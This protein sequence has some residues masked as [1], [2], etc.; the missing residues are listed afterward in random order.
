MGNPPAL[1]TPP[2][3]PVLSAEKKAA[4]PNLKELPKLFSE[5]PIERIPEPAL[6]SKM[7]ESRLSLPSAPRLT[8]ISMSELEKP[9]AI[10]DFGIPEPSMELP[11]IDVPDITFPKQGKQEVSDAI[12]K[13]AAKEIV[14]EK[15]A[16][17]KRI[18]EGIPPIEE[19]EQQ[20]KEENYQE[21]S[22]PE[23]RLVTEIKGTIFIPSNQFN[24]VKNALGSIKDNIKNSD[25]ALNKIMGLK[26]L[27][28]SA[29]EGWHAGVESIQR[30]LI[31]IDRMLFEKGQE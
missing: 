16:K 28:D 11:D 30:K 21:M 15:A 4:A 3:T 26:N 25:K 22:V 6:L 12:K 9:R 17:K 1:P 7:Q 27:Q 18:P 5:T 2:P 29:F 23:P 31:L 14:V 19:Y 8:A 10:D 24:A 13:A 20:R